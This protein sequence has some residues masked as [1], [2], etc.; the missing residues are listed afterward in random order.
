MDQSRR[1]FLKMLG[2]AIP[3]AAA[4]PSYF[5]A[6]AGGW[7]SG[8]FV[9]GL[10]GYLDSQQPAWEWSRQYDID[11]VC[12]LFSV[13]RH[14]VGRLENVGPVTFASPDIALMRSEFERYL[15]FGRTQRS[16]LFRPKASITVRIS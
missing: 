10:N 2:L 5:F 8:G 12:K 11:E 15:K 1:G 3:V 16:Q 14:M 9:S 7:Y 13:P 6:P 4:A